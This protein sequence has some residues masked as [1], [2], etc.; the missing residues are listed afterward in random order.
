MEEV[1]IFQD[2]RA[3]RLVQLSQQV[4]AG[5]YDPI[6]SNHVAYGGML[7][8]VEVEIRIGVREAKAKQTQSYRKAICRQQVKQGIS[9]LTWISLTYCGYSVDVPRPH[10]ALR[11]TR[12]DRRMLRASKAVILSNFLDFVQQYFRVWWHN[13]DFEEAGLYPWVELSWQQA[14]SQLEEMDWID[15]FFF[16]DIVE[17]HEVA[18]VKDL[19]DGR[20]CIEFDEPIEQPQLYFDI[21]ADVFPSESATDPLGVSFYQLNNDMPGW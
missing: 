11:L 14:R 21:F 10:D 5:D 6:L 2:E 16:D 13:D 18:D 12:Q 8:P 1:L 7:S 17:S 19:V 9:G 3:R 4:G 15:L 20:Q